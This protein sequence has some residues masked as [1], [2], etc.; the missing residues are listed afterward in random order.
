V[1]VAQIEN[2]RIC[3]VISM[4][5]KAVSSVKFSYYANKAVLMKEENGRK[6]IIDEQKNITVGSKLKGIRK[7][8]KLTLAYVAKEAKMTVPTLSR[9]EN[10]TVTPALESL[11]DLLKFYGMSL[12]EFLG[13][14]KDDV[15][16]FESYGLSQSVLLA[17]KY[18]ALFKGYVPERFSNIAEIINMMFAD[19][20]YYVPIFQNL[21]A[22]FSSEKRESVERKLEEV[23]PSPSVREKLT[24]ALLMES[25]LAALES[26]Y[27]NAVSNADR[28]FL[29]D[30]DGSAEN[31]TDHAIKYGR[32]HVGAGDEAWRETGLRHRETKIAEEKRREE[33]KAKNAACSSKHG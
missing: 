28:Y 17:L 2:L 8:K 27:K 21:T 5:L 33:G 26:I 25:I 31:I 30:E 18:D 22:Y 32:E 6:V 11:R 23:A 3:R 1:H 15:S 9:Y 13:V 14:A 10:D 4:L 16:V 29:V 19:Y 20:S 7:D 24:E 12:T